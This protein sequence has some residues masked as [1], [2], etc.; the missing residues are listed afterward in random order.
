MPFDSKQLDGIFRRTS[1]LC[2]ICHKKLCRKNYGSFGSRGAWEVEHS[3]PQCGGGTHRSNNLY[4]ACI[5]C[6]RSKGKITTRTVRRWNGQTRAPM[7]SERRKSAR[8]ENTFVAAAFGGLAGFAIAGPVGAI[9]GAVGGGKFG[10]SL[11]PDKTG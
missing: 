1:G 2:H 10:N 7:S 9:I 8:D 4:A 5:S 3:V 6:N 11:N